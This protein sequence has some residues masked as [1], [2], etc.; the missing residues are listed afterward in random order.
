MLLYITV[1]H[2]IFHV[3]LLINNVF[4]II[5]ILYIYIY[6]YIYTC[7]YTYIWYLKHH[8]VTFNHCT[9]LPHIIFCIMLLYVFKYFILLLCIITFN[10]DYCHVL[11]HTPSHVWPEFTKLLSIVYCLLSISFLVSDRS[12]FNFFE[13]ESNR[14]YAPK[15]LSIRTAIF[16][17]ELA[18]FD[19]FFS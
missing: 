6:L 19:C 5:P 9:S 11:L 2:L 16:L 1:Y 12:S 4:L 15:L 18:G 13:Y 14:H 17:V 10:I 3:V 8:Y 7:I